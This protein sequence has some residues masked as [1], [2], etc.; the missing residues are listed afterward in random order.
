[1]Q[2]WGPFAESELSFRTVQGKR[3][4]GGNRAKNFAAQSPQNGDFLSSPNRGT[5]LP[6]VPAKP[7]PSSRL[8]GFAFSL[9]PPQD[10]TC[11]RWPPS[12]PAPLAAFTGSPPQPLAEPTM[13]AADYPKVCTKEEATSAPPANHRGVNGH[14]S[15]QLSRE[16]RPSNLAR[17]LIRKSDSRPLPPA[18]PRRRG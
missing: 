16:Q 18:P 4:R 14:P 10:I 9:S 13:A 11:L 3:G 6:Q 7:G 8:F 5:S 2:A 17:I 12:P 15:L 1:M